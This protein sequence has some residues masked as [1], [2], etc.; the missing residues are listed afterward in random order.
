MKIE[1]TQEDIK[2]G[3]K[4][5]CTR[6]PIALAIKRK[7]GYT[8]SVGTRVC[9]SLDNEFQ[10]P[11]IAQDFISNFDHGNPVEPFTFELEGLEEP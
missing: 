8:M 11:K 10:L 5:E 7:V 2:A 6:C 9:G 1:V 3:R 4:T